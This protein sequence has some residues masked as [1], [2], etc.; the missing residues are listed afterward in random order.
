MVP[1]SLTTPLPL[2]SAPNTSPPPFLSLTINFSGSTSSTSLPQHIS[3]NTSSPTSHPS[4]SQHSDAVTTSQLFSWM[5][6]N[7]TFGT[8]MSSHEWDLED[9]DYLPHYEYQP[10][11]H[12]TDVWT[13]WASG[14]NGY[15]PVWDLMERWGPKWHRNMARRKTESARRKVIMDLICE[16][17]K[18]SNRDLLLTL[19]F[20]QQK[21]EP[22]FKSHPFSDFLT[23]GSHA[24]FQ[25]VLKAAKGYP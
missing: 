2:P 12:I 20:L 9:G 6:L 8:C 24:R 17:L 1:P 21:Y 5:V 10:V 4:A 3:Y 18:K 22:T 7:E 15:I 23:K 16:L 13:E 11:S 19:H 14:L 25:E